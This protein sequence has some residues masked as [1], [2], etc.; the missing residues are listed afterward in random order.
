M[1]L[2]LGLCSPNCPFPISLPLS[3]S[4]SLEPNCL[5]RRRRRCGRSDRVLSGRLHALGCHYTLLHSPP[6]IL[7]RLHCHYTL[8]RSPL[9]PATLHIYR[10]LT[11]LRLV[12]A[13]SLKMKPAKSAQL[14]KHTDSSCCCCACS[15]SSTSTFTF[16]SSFSASFYSISIQLS[17]GSR[18]L[19]PAIC[20]SLVSCNSDPDADPDLMLTRRLS[21]PPG[22]DWIM[23]MAAEVSA[24]LARSLCHYLFVNGAASWPSKPRHASHQYNPR[25]TLFPPHLLPAQL[26]GCLH[27]DWSF[28]VATRRPL[29]LALRGDAGMWVC[30]CAGVRVALRRGSL[31]GCGCGCGCGCAAGH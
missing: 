10:A 28:A 22:L 12:I 3:L 20:D 4:F 30:V 9:D 19:Y 27:C 18:S 17:F 24:C 26:S 14:H 7:P 15:S 8:L 6:A 5:S 25:Y 11:N 31:C 16:T 1:Q 23:V 13:V 29:T 2:P 21:L